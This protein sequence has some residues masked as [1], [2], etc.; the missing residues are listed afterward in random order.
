MAGE[1][2]QRGKLGGHCARTH[3]EQGAVF[4]L[5][6]GAFW[7][8]SAALQ[9]GANEVAGECG[10]ENDEERTFRCGCAVDKI[11]VEAEEG[12]VCVGCGEGFSEFEIL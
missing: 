11:C 1:S 9:A 4:D 5:A 2:A 6:A 8:G 7:F 3:P 10:G 12:W